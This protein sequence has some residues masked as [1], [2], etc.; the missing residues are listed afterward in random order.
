MMRHVSQRNTGNQSK[1]DEKNASRLPLACQG[2]SL[3]KGVEN[4]VGAEV[5]EKLGPGERTRMA[6]PSLGVR[7]AA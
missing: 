4:G 1:R 6:N 2:K 7:M 5:G 3:G